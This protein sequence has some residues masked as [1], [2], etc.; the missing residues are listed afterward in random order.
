[1]GLYPTAVNP[2]QFYGPSPWDV[3]HRVS[4]TANYLLPEGQ[5]LKALTSG[6][7]VSTITIYQSGYPMTV[8]TSAPFT[9]RRRLQRRRRQP[10]IIR[11]SRTTRCGTRSMTI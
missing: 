2:H 5:T 9:R 11:T 4:L 1:M 6:W 7:G 10:A 8:F 3:P